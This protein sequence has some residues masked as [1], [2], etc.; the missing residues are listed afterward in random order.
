MKLEYYLRSMARSSY[1]QQ[2]YNSSKEC[3]GIHIFENVSNISGIQCLFLYWLKVYNLLYNEM[4]NGGWQNL[5]KDVINDDDRCDAF[6]FWRGKEID[7][8]SHEQKK[9]LKN[10]KNKKGQKEFKIYKGK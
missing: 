8:E 3:S 9:E 7:K 6:L 2:I 4:V 10:H 1:W 5:D